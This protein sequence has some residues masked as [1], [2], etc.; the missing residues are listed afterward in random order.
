V[1]ER[2]AVVLPWRV[3]QDLKRDY[4]EDL[5]LFEG[6]WSRALAGLF[7]A[8]VGGYALLVAQGFALYVMTTLALMIIAVLGLNLLV[9]YTGQISLGHAAFL[10]IGAYA[11]V[12]LYTQGAPLLFTV[13]GAA[14]I[15]GAFGFLVGIPA[16]RLAGPYLAIATLGF[17]VAVD[18]VLGRWDSVTGGRM[19]LGVPAPELFGLKLADVKS[20]FVLCLAFCVLVIVGVYNLTRS[21]VGRAFVAIRDN[22]IAAAAMGVNPVRYKTLAFALSAF[23]TGLA[24]ALYAHLFDRINPQNF[25]ILMSIELLVMV[26]VGGLASVLGSILGAALMVL[27]PHAISDFRDYQAIVVGGILIAVLLFEPMGMRGRWLR[28]K[29]YFRAWPF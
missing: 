12:I 15:S 17:Q 21:R 19:G 5:T 9:G 16:L 25:T 6:P 27:L 1:V 11:H 28:I 29:Y 8:L 14:V 3:A 22:D 18:Q 23:V 10:A 4:R 20:Y 7:L 26:V 24:G 2:L 13:L